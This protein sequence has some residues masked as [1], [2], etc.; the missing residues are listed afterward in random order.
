MIEKKTHSICN[1]YLIGAIAIVTLYCFFS[2]SAL[3]QPSEAEPPE[4]QKL[5]WGGKIEPANLTA[6][7]PENQIASSDR[8][9]EETGQS[10]PS[11][12]KRIKELSE[13]CSLEPQE[14]PSAS[15]SIATDPDLTIKPIFTM[16]AFNPVVLR[17]IPPLYTS[18]ALEGEGIWQSAGMP[19]G[20]NGEEIMWRTSYRPSIDFPNAIV[21]M[22]LL[23]MKK[24]TM[25]LYIGSTEPGGSNATSII[26]PQLRPELVAVTNALWKQKH[27]G[28]AGSVQRGG[29]IKP[30]GAGMATIVIYKDNSVDILEWNDTIPLS[31]VQD[32]RQLRHL[33]VKDGKVVDSVIKGGKPADSEIG[34]GMLLMEEP[35]TPEQAWWGAMNYGQ[36]SNFTSGEYWFIATRSAFGIRKDGNLVFAVGH[37]ISTKDLAKALVLAGCDRAVHADANPHNVLGNL[38]Y[39]GGNSAK[40]AK[41]SPE[42]RDTLNRYDKSYTSDFFG[43]FIKLDERNS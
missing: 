17:K 36:Q 6:K 39:G 31:L 3:A 1:A 20:P 5:L 23:D 35:T 19:T 4:W 26:E 27:S 16:S 37:H 15:S 30:L 43:F 13:F 33:I 38:Y 2:S 29:T 18:P 28:E 42:Q 41:L 14:N 21:H 34:L 10:L 22:L 8:A 24:I 40:R 12:E 9:A 32:A 7:A 25:K 11:Q